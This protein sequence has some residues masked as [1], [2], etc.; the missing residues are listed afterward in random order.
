MRTLSIVSVLYSVSFLGT[1]SMKNS[2]KK[3]DQ[4]GGLDARKKLGEEVN[5]LAPAPYK[6]ECRVY[7]VMVVS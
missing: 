7:P 4:G 6:L 1:F 3:L 5:S 2:Q